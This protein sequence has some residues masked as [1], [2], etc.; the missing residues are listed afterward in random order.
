MNCP[1]CKTDKIEP[2]LGILQ[3]VTCTHKFSKRI[4]D[5][6]YWSDLYENTYNTIYRK[7]DEKRK[8]M[9]LNEIDWISNFKKFQGSFLDVGCAHGDFF[10]S[11]PQNLKKIGIDLS[12]NII[13]EAKKLHP[14]CNFHKMTLCN[15]STK[16]KFDFIQFRGVIQHSVDP[17]NNLKCATDLLKKNGIILVSSL[18]NFSSFTSRYYKE[19]FGFYTPD[20]SPHFFTNKSFH[21]MIKSLNLKITQE[22]S[23]YLG[24]PY[25]NP[26]KDILLFFTNKFQNKSNP[27]FFGNI[28]NYILQLDLS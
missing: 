3:C 10:S 19:K 18:P 24:T 6:S 1:I 27:P 15:F 4:T 5:D 28:K 23:P 26:L 12:T 7:Q 22:I 13:E 11:L 8:F 21:Y 16:D 25:A 17:I 2:F 9:Y 20:L 14:D